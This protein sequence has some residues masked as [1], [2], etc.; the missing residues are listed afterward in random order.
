MNS[1]PFL[2]RYRS[3]ATN[4]HAAAGMAID[5]RQNGPPAGHITDHSKNGD[6]GRKLNHEEQIARPDIKFQQA[7]RG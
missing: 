6:V 7:Q 5:G 3:H 4:P 2:I 1:A